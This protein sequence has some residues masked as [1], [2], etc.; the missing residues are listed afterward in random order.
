MLLSGW[1][2]NFCKRIHTRRQ[3][4][5]VIACNEKLL[6]GIPRKYAATVDCWL[7]HCHFLRHLTFHII[8]HQR[9]P[10]Y[11]VACTPHITHYMCTYVLSGMCAWQH[12][13]QLRDFKAAAKWML[14]SSAQPVWLL[15]LLCLHLCVCAYVSFYFSAKRLC[16][17]MCALDFLITLTLPNSTVIATLT[18]R[19]SAISLNADNN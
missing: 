4:L 17:C 19:Q 1:C 15:L 10:L 7:R 5:C 16:V 3:R 13:S 18:L 11:H 2:S 8:H 9:I 12:K 6:N 14:L